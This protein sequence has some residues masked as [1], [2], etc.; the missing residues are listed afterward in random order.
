MLPLSRHGNAAGRGRG[1]VSGWCV[2]RAGEHNADGRVSM[3]SRYVHTACEEKDGDVR[4][5]HGRVP[6]GAFQPGGAM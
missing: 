5:A 1:R 3:C 6:H 2:C 4:Q